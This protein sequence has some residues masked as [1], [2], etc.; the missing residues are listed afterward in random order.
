MILQ[1]RFWVFTPRKRKYYSHLG[2]PMDRGASWLQSLESKS[3]TQLSD[4][5]T[6]TKSK[7]YMHPH[8]H[9]TVLKI[10]KIWK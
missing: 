8:A 1:F 2:N 5:T 4:Q 10:A 6:S 7:T 9:G 3:Q